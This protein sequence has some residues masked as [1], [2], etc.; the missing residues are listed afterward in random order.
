MANAVTTLS[1]W[2]DENVRVPAVLEA[3]DALRRPEPMPPTRTSV[4]TLVVVATRPASA[5]RAAAAVHELAGRHP[6]RVLTLVVDRSA[7]DA[8][9]DAQLALLGSESEGH[10]VWFED[11]RLDVR[12]PVVDHLDSLI[13]PF[14]IADL[15][16]V[17]WFVDG[18]PDPTDP[19]L[20]AADLLLVDARDFGETEC[21][22]T[23]AS[24][25]VHPLVD[26]SW[27]RLRPW[28]ELLAA[29]FEGAGVAPFLHGIRSV[30]VEGKTGPRHLLAGWIASRLRVPSAEIHLRD[31]VHVTIE[32][33][34]EID[35]RRGTFT[36]ERTSDERVV[37]ARGDIDGG[38]TAEIV[39]PLVE[40]T[41]AWGLASALSALE[42]DPVYE[43]ALDAAIVLSNR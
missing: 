7:T 37:R 36:V 22:S 26:L 28:R 30:R 13:E 18:L 9:L 12:G 33:I 4:L 17:A 23:L 29:L 31:A 27:H 34:S 1:L 25:R 8:C 5:E 3:L 40:P 24:L 11:V 10:P 21:F 38:P 19:L 39:V 32:I 43:A 14:T 15:P 16:V 20:T 2:A 42:R 41:P 6:A 35:G